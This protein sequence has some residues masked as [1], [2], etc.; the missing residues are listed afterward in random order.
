MTILQEKHFAV[1]TE[2]AGNA[3]ET[4]DAGKAGNGE[5]TVSVESAVR[6]GCED[7]G[8]GAMAVHALPRMRTLSWRK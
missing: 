6:A 8:K 2:D 3:V 5:Y 4:K 7:S 1:E